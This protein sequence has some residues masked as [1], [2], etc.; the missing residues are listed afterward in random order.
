MLALLVTSLLAG[1]SVSLPEKVFSA[2]TVAEFTVRLEPTR[3][4]ALSGRVVFPSDPALAPPK[5]QRLLTQDSPCLGAARRKKLL[6]LLAFFDADG[7]QLAGVEQDKGQATDLDPDYLPILEAVLE[8]KGWADERMRAVAPEAL[9]QEQ[10][11]ALRSENPYLKRLAQSFLAAHDASSVVDAAWG[12]PGSPERR[13]Q[14]ARAAVP[15]GVVCAL[16]KPPPEK[17]LP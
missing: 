16:K 9:W 6:K 7:K 14:E 8:A 1:D 17:S 3:P 4:P 11:R 12:P 13:Q 15:T 10:K 5:L 2:A